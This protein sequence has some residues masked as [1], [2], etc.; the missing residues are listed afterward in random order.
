MP[1][2]KCITISLLAALLLACTP[3]HKMQEGAAIGAV[4]G[5]GAGAAIGH[6]SGNAG[7]GA[8]VG[9]ASGALLG[10]AAGSSLEDRG[11]GKEYD[12]MLERQRKEQ[13]RQRK[14]LEEIERQKHYDDQYR[15][16]ESTHSKE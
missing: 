7:A 5:A 3:R 11:K 2:V 15:R 1:K 8:V 13:E 14:E 16:F 9:A 4:T 10:G 6:Q 12:A